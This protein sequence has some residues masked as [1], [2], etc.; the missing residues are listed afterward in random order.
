MRRPRW[1]NGDIKNE[2]KLAANQRTLNGQKYRKRSETMSNWETF[3]LAASNCSLCLLPFKVWIPKG[4]QLGSVVVQQL[5]WASWSYKKGWHWV[6][7]SCTGSPWMALDLPELHWIALSC[8]TD[9]GLEVQSLRRRVGCPI[10]C[11]KWAIWMVY[12]FLGAIVQRD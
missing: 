11:N 4:L 1:T 9:C 8:H 12:S 5:Q 10:W 2:R 6:A 3:C 7:L